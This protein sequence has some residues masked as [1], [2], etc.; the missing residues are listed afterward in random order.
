MKLAFPL[1]KPVTDDNRGQ[2][3]ESAFE[4]VGQGTDVRFLIGPISVTDDATP[5]RRSFFFQEE[6]KDPVNAFLSS[7]AL[8]VVQG[9][10]QVRPRQLTSPVLYPVPRTKQIRER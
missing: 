3:V 6:T 1:C 5:G 2:H 9:D 8:N 4:Q 10:N 7:F